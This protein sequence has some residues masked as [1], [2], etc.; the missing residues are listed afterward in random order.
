MCKWGTNLPAKVLTPGCD[1]TEIVMVDA[2]LRQL[3]EAINAGGFRTIGCCCGHGK[4]KGSI[5][6]ADG[7]ELVIRGYHI[8]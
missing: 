5:L 3:V 6:L 1:G 7:R 4:G 2:C 8:H